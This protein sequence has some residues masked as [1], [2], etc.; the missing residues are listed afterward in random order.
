VR[1]I[2][3]AILNTP[4]VLLALLNIVT[5]FKMGKVSKRRFR[6]QIFMWVLIL[7]V[8]LCSF[9]LYNYLN[10]R[11]MLDSTDLSAFDIVQ[12][13]AIIGLMYVLNNMRQKAEETERRLRDLHQE[14]SI[15]LSS[16]NE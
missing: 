5:R 12:T 3:L 10:N 7:T 11:P 14:L 6:R 13:T 8:L 2:V 1:Y 4:I 15:K 16:K 9:P